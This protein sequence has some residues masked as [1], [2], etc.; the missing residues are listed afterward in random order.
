MKW[1]N[2]LVSFLVCTCMISLTNFPVLAKEKSND[3]GTSYYIDSVNG[4]DSSAGTSEDEAFASLSKINS[5]TLTEGDH[6]Y[7]KNGSTFNEQLKPKGKGTEDNPIVITHYGEGEDLPVIN[8]G[9]KIYDGAVNN[10]SSAVLIE[11]M[12]YVEISYLEVTNDDVFN[13]TDSNSD[14]DNIKGNNQRRIGIHITINEDADTFTENQRAWKG[15]TVSHCYVHDVDGDEQRSANKVNGGIGVEVFFRNSNAVYP[16]F[17]CVTLDSNKIEKVDRTGIKG[18]RLTELTLKD[19]DG[20]D[21]VRYNAVRAESEKNQAGRNFVVKN[22]ELSNIGGDGI[23]IDST[24]KSVVEHNVLYDHTKRSTLA[25]AGIWCWNTQDVCFQYNESYGGPSYNQ[26]GCSYDC[27]YN[28]SGTIYQYNYSHDTPMGFML[29]M[30]GNEMDIVRYNISQNDGTAWRHFSADSSTKSYIYNNAFYYDGAKW[31]WSEGNDSESLRKNYEFINNVF[32]NYNEEIPTHWGENMNWNDAVFESNA[33]YEASGKHGENEIPD[34]VYGDP[35]FVNP[36]SGETKSWESLDGYQLKDNSSLINQGSYVYLDMSGTKMLDDRSYYT[37]TKDFYGNSL[38]NGAPDIG[39]YESQSSSSH[40]ITLE[41]N[42]IYRISNESQ[43]YI[44]YTDSVLSLN[45][46]RT[47]NQT[48]ILIKSQSG[49][50]LKCA[51][52]GVDNVYLSVDDGKLVISERASIWSIDDL[53]NGLVKFTS[54]GHTLGYDDDELTLDNSFQNQWYMKLEETSKSFNCGGQSVEG[55]SSDQE[56]NQSNQTSGRY[57]EVQILGNDSNDVYSTGV[58]GEKFG[59]KIYTSN[60]ASYN[61]KLNFHELKDVENRTFDILINGEIYKEQYTITKE[62]QVE[63]IGNIYPQ[64]GIIDIQFIAAYN[65]DGV[66]T[67]P[68]LNGISLQKATNSDTVTTINCGS[69]GVDGLNGDA[70]FPANGSGYYGESSVIDFGNA[71]RPSNDG[72]MPTAMQTGREGEEFSYKFKLQPG[73]YRLKLMFNDGAKDAKEG[74]RVFDIYVNG[75]LIEKDFDIV[76]AAGSARQGVD[77]T[78]HVKSQDGILDVRFKASKGK[79]L[80]NVVIVDNLSTEETRENILLNKGAT[81]TSVENDGLAASKAFDG[82]QATR[83]GSGF[84]DNQS[85]TVDMGKDYLVDTVMVDWTYGAYATSY[86]VE[87]S[88]DGQEWQTVKTVSSTRPGLNVITFIPEEGR[89]LRIVGEKRNSVYGISITELEAYGTEIVGDPF[90]S[91]EINNSGNSLYTTTIGLSNIYKRYTTMT[92]SMNYDPDTL[93][94][95]NNVKEL[96]E[97]LTLTSTSVDEESG[98]IIYSFEIKRTDAFTLQPEILSFDFLAKG[99]R[100]PVN[101]QVT[102]SDAAA[103]LAEITP[104]VIYIPNEISAKLLQELIDEAKLQISEAK[105]GRKPGEYRKDDI[106]HFQEVIDYSKKVL[107]SGNESEFGSTY[108][109]LESA[110]SD[111]KNA[112]IKYQYSHYYKN[113]SDEARFNYELNKAHASIE[114]GTLNICL[115]DGGSTAVDLDAPKLD[116]GTFI[117]KFDIDSLKDQIR[118]DLKH[119]DN[120][121]IEVGYENGSWF[122]GG[123]N[124]KWGYFPN[125]EDDVLYTDQTNEVIV[126]FEKQDDGQTKVTLTVNGHEVGSIMA[127]FSNES[128]IYRLWTRHTEKNFKIHEVTYTNAPVYSIN[129]IAGEHGTISEEGQT[130][131][132]GETDK[133]FI[134]VPDE[135]YEVDKVLVDGKEVQATDCYTFEYIESNHDIQVTFRKIADKSELQNVYKEYQ[136][137]DKTNY[138]DESWKVFEQAMAN[139]EAMIES[140]NQ[141]TQDQINDCL[142][143][144]QLSKQSLKYKSADYQQLD[145]VIATIPDD[146]S[147]YTEQSVQ[148]LNE[149]LNQVE[150][151]LNITDQK[152]VNQMVQNIEKALENLELRKE[153]KPVVEVT[154]SDGSQSSQQTEAI[155]TGDNQSI[156]GY[157]ILGM[158]AVVGIVVLKKQRIKNKN[159]LYNKK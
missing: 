78:R 37:A 151:G 72:G 75:E 85:I 38:Y 28:S 39:V 14:P 5:M 11:N 115:E 92:I 49:Y 21:S 16:Y 135:G 105:E 77:I 130:K 59:Y 125:I 150:R 107:E 83:W 50:K 13:K 122:W 40:E 15:I 144:L 22:N 17:D 57:G 142:K 19:T 73:N 108:T 154:P 87:L 153:Q 25:N 95:K 120:S 33:V 112:V 88:Q 55:Y 74:D 48:F 44:Q 82:N 99:N 7:L 1:K 43:K 12:E 155:Q 156:T 91:S 140:D 124:G 20:G 131:V 70:Q 63:E 111:F 9:G 116:S 137:I 30:G 31:K 146:L 56:F 26:D 47:E 109:Q 113:Y 41:E 104:V 147:I 69:S 106:D 128:G 84:E 152:K 58:T 54:D 100:S 110:M 90:V 132:Y 143:A 62:Q 123:A 80:V 98:K 53:K 126:T 71:G 6:V 46:L 29:L 138:T 60:S 79:A 65:E 10:T 66:K 148:A 64:D 35:Q 32:Y 81:C 86:R 97:Y 23:L 93:K 76:K 139:A 127:T 34:A 117:M 157:V 158:L 114:N 42:G 4:S 103:H 134:F 102:L 89:Y 136:K 94:Y 145:K 118:F 141:Y 27:D 96:N 24:I 36:G 68:I 3:V 8:G 121:N 52:S 51:D 129:A 18:V 133:T 2:V 149:A 159:L 61:V 119:T 101:I 45:D 67:N